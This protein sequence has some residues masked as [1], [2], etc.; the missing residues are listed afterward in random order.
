[1]AALAP[2]LPFLGPVMQGVS[3]ISS[4]VSGVTSASRDIN[5]AQDTAKR[6]AS[7][8]LSDA[9]HEAEGKKMEMERL[10]GTQNVRTAASGRTIGEDSA[11]AVELETLT[12]S[13]REIEDVLLSGRRRAS[14]AT[15]QGQA[16]VNAA[17][18]AGRSALFSG[19]GSLGSLATAQF[20]KPA[21]PAK[22][23][24]P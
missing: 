15:L 7:E 19:F 17:A 11:L 16:Q 2:L 9:Q 12:L 10:R 3:A 1:M 22:P 20:G 4:I 5:T 18:T 24:T 13:N 21:T 23:A 8:A 6:G 14:A